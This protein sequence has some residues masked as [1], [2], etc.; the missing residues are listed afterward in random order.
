MVRIKSC[1][2]GSNFRVVRRAC[3]TIATQPLTVPFLAFLAL[4]SCVASGQSPPVHHVS[5]SG[6]VR[7]SAPEMPGAPTG[8]NRCILCHHAE[9]EGYS[10]S[11][12][13]HSLRR[14]DHEPD[15]AVNA[16]GSKITMNSSSMGYC[17][18]WEN[19]GEAID[20]RSD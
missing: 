6:D 7:N 14:A 10:R 20:Y 9:V 1:A 3:R 2:F 16:H 4:L 11:T 19:G 8:S 5:A 15:G 17:K 12:M 13:A 18:R